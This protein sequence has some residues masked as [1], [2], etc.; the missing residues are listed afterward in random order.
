[1]CHHESSSKSSPPTGS[2]SGPNKSDG[3]CSTKGDASCPPQVTV[4]VTITLS[5]AVACPGHPLPMTAVGTPSGG[6]YAWTVSGGGAELVDSSGAPASTGNSLFLRSF[7]PDNTNGNIPEQNATVSVTYTHPNGTANDSKPVKIHKIDFVVTN[8]AINKGVMQAN[9][10]PG[11]VTLG[12]APGVATISTDPQVEI[13]LDASCPRKAACAANHR[14]AWLQTMRT[15][16]EKA[17]Y[18]HTLFEETTTLPK[19][20]ALDTAPTKPFYDAPIPFTGDRDRETVHHE[21]SPSATVAWIDGRPGAPPPPPPLNRK[22]RQFSAGNGLTAWLVVQ[23]VEWSVHDLDHSFVFLKN[24]DWSINLACAVDVTQP[25][26]N[27]CTPASAIP[28]VGPLGTGK[29]ARSPTL[30]DPTYNA[31]VTFRTTPQPAL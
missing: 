13:R 28:V 16:S 26:G 12:S 11:D 3:G 25:V 22:L 4:T 23:N 21:D 29:G 2:G 8:T 10:N 17:R 19:R 24:L 6:T 7:Q 18:R 27:R 1:M 30:V 20:D 15:S 5:P 31:S 14:V 9:E